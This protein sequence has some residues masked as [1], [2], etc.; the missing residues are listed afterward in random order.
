MQINKT[1]KSISKSINSTGRKLMSVTA[2]ALFA[3]GFSQVPA[4][5]QKTEQTRQITIVQD[6]GVVGIVPGQ[7]L[8]IT[9][10]NPEE[11]GVTVQGHVKI[12]DGTRVVF[13]T[14]EVEIAPGQ[15]HSFEINRS[16]ISSPGDPRTGRFRAAG[17]LLGIRKASVERSKA[18]IDKLP[19]S[20]EIV[21]YV[22]G[23]TVAL[24]TTRVSLV[25]I[26]G[27]PVPVD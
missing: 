26:G 13:E 23:K 22:S 11:S 3:L 12:L 14:P 7:T 6:L 18:R 4:Q 9:L 1:S 15:F 21:D 5:A 20:I 17:R 16:D 19:L 25:P 10:A 27:I 8:S 24:T 2:F